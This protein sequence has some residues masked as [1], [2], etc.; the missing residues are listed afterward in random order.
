MTPGA[1]LTGKLEELSR[2]IYK[3]EDKL[4]SLEKKHSSAAKI[5]ERMVLAAFDVCPLFFS[6]HRSCRKLRRN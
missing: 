6:K 4:Q 3:I 5:T 1:K 2:D